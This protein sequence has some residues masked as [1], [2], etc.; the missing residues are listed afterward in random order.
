MERLSE[1]LLDHIVSEVINP[2]PS[3]HRPFY[4]DVISL[5]MV[6]RKFRRIAEPHIYR[7]LVLDEDH[8]EILLQIMSSRP[9][10]LRYVRAVSA[11]VYSRIANG[12]RDFIMCL[13][14][15]KELDL[16]IDECALSEIVAV[17]K[18]QTVTKLRLSGVVAREIE[19]WE[20]GGWGFENNTLTSLDLSFIKAMN[21]GGSGDN[22]RQ[23]TFFT[24]CM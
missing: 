8:D 20:F 24:N 23:S 12:T 10:L 13:P 9:E 22:I 2:L 19:D 17:L 15:L 6:S 1:E 7:S 11:M 14:N 4:D 18:L 21:Q 3:K 16:D 5:S